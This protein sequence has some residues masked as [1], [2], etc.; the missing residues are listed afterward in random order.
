MTPNFFP[1]TDID[2]GQRQAGGDADLVVVVDDLDATRRLHVAHTKLDPALGVLVVAARESAV[3][4]RSQ[5]TVQSPRFA[6]HH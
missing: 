5:S 3:I 4:L 2:G 6:Q 1:L